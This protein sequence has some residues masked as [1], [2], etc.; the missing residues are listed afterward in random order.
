MVQQF[1]R[2]YQ[3]A[4]NNWRVKEL[5]RLQSKR[6]KMICQSNNRGLYYQVLGTVNTEIGALQESIAEIQALKAGK[7]WREVCW[8]HQESSYCEGNSAI[9]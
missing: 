8:I 5:K 4:E 3:I 2:S 6:N 1:V 7:Q 9:H